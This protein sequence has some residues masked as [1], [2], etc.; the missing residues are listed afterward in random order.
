MGNRSVEADN[1]P[2]VK[3]AFKIQLSRKV[4]EEIP[5]IQNESLLLLNEGF[6]YQFYQFA[7]ILYGELQHATIGLPLKYDVSARYKTNHMFLLKINKG[8]LETKIL[9]YLDDSKS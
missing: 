5:I 2:S 4:A 1:F 7:K 9:I 6:K 8:E 3:T